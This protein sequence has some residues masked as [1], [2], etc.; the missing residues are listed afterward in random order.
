MWHIKWIYVNKFTPLSIF[1]FFFDEISSLLPNLARQE[2][3]GE[4]WTSNNMASE[5]SGEVAKN[6]TDIP[7]AVFVVR[8][9][10]GK[11]FWML[12]LTT[13]LFLA[14]QN[15]H[16]PVT[17]PIN[18]LT[19]PVKIPHFHDFVHARLVE[20][21]TRPWIKNLCYWVKWVFKNFHMKSKFS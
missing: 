18:N 15:V 19:W 6:R 14:F 3:Q 2:E 13:A 16:K 12:I 1:Y 21:V 9:F 5:K 11:S 4:T 8:F 7:Q 10:D 17:A 20:Q